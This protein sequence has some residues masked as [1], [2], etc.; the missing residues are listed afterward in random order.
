[1]PVQL[2]FP[3]KLDKYNG[4]YDIP[5]NQSW[6]KLLE[7]ILGKDSCFL[8]DNDEQPK[9]FI[10]IYLNNNKVSNLDGLYCQHGD[11]LMFISATSGG[12]VPDDK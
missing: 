2:S 4:R 8:Y 3:G 6:Y 5:P 10:A 11:S 1:M 12:S 7:I 9:A